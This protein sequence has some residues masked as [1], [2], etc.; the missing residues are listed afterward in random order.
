MRINASCRFELS[1]ATAA[2]IG[3]SEST[4]ASRL[5]AS[6]VEGDDFVQISAAAWEELRPWHPDTFPVALPR[7]SMPSGP[8][9]QPLFLWIVKLDKIPGSVEVSAA[10]V[11]LLCGIV[12]WTALSWHRVGVFGADIIYGQVQEIDEAAFCL[13][14]STQVS[15]H[16]QHQTAAL[17]T[18][19]LLD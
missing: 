8:L 3:S 4:I 14:Q 7:A 2:S 10:R 5:Q 16:S 15:N 13:A 11:G 18:Q 12:C 9:L 19:A 1:K 6:L 17:N